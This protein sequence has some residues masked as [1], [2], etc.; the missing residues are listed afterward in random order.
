MLPRKKWRILNHDTNRSII[1]TILKNRELPADYMDPFKLSERMHSPYL[2]PDMDKGVQR[3]Q[4]AINNGEK[5]VIFGDYDVDGI[6][7]TAIMIFFFRKIGY[8]VQY[9]LPHREKDGYGLRPAG[10]DK[11][12]ALAAK[13]IITVDNGITSNEA[14]DY[15]ASLG[16]DVVVTDHHLQEGELPNAC[17]VINPNRVDSKY[18]FKS[19]CG[20]TVAFKLIYA[21]G[22][23][24]MQEDDYKQFLLNHLDLVAI[25]TIA[26]V[27]PLR[28]ENYAIVKLGLKVLSNT[29]KPGLVELK[30]IS[31][32][33]EREVT[34]ISV[35]FFLAP[36]LNA[37]GRLEEADTSVNL[38]ISQSKEEA[39]EISVYLNELNKK[40]QKMQSDYLNSAFNLLPAEKDKVGKVIF[41]ENEEWQPGLIGLVA[42]QL[43]EKY[44]RPAFAFTLDERGNYIGSARSVDSFHITNA[45]T[46]FNHYFLNYGGHSK[47]AGLTV[48]A[49]NYQKFKNEFFDYANNLIDEKDLI[50]ELVIDSVIDIDQV[51][52]S[53]TRLIQDVGPFGE[54]NPEPVLVI[55]KAQIQDMKLLS[56]G[57]HL[58]LYAQKG[59]QIFECV[60]WRAGEYKDSLVFR[61]VVDLAFR[62]SINSWQGVERLQLVVEDI[63]KSEN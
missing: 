1:D 61:E 40:R 36:R 56:N 45:L 57:K 24:L 6:T 4:Q 54:G 30:K 44:A 25:G 62:L 29:L 10:V 43:K 28:D 16:I 9:I 11:A 55:E 51:N 7:S 41:V 18:P 63:R 19:I 37:S 20:V 39:K 59:N 50:T 3:I 47:A 23:N 52:L 21:L 46:N 53:V 26:D 32:V 60:W 15:A 48:L 5:I 8:P 22:E 38:L 42:G 2:L 14:I 34:P 12:A 35:G 17:A 49:E 27:M 31:G 58:K 33:K 13:L